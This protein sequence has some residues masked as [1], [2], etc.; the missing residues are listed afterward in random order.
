MF[1]RVFDKS[2][3][4]YYK[5]IV[6]GTINTGWFLQYIVLNSIE[7]RFELVDYLDK[8]LKPAKPH[9]EVIQSNCDEFVTYEGAFIL[10]YKKLLKEKWKELDINSVSGYPDICDNQIFVAE[11]IEYKIVPVGKYIIQLRQLEDVNQWNYI[12]TQDDANRFMKLFVGFHDSTMDKLIYEEDY[13]YTKATIVFDNSGWYGIVE[14]C[15]EGV[16]EINIR[17]P[18]ENCDRYIY[19]ATMIVENETVFWADSY[20][21]KVDL[22]YDG[23]YIKAL[24]LKWRKIG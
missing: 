22:S 9:I 15:F 24:S 3:S 6:Y 21:E 18:K 20:M 13:G 8:S 16:Q 2:T 7:N 10:K 23:S 1:V 11:I 19:D 5:S 14:L 4:Q 12:N 17:P